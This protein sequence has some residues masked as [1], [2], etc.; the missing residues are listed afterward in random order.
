MQVSRW[1]SRKAAEL[2]RKP[3]LLHDRTWALGL[4]LACLALYWPTLSPSVVLSDGGE[5]QM[6]SYVLGVAHRTG[7]PLY[8]LLGWVVTHLPL[9]GDVAYRLNLFSMFSASAAMAVVYLLLRELDVR[10]GVAALSTLL[11]AS[12]P[13]LWMHAAAA[14]VYA[15]AVFFVALGSWLLLR[16]GRGK[17]PLWLV[18]L[19]FGLGLTHH[20]TF[21]LL[22]PAVL[23]YILLVEPRLPLRPRRWLPALV[24]LLLPLLL[25]AWIPLRAAHF[26]AQPGLQGEILGVPKVVASGYISTWYMAVGPVDFFL[27]A[28]Y[29]GDVVRSVGLDPA[30]VSRYLAMAQ[31]Q[32]P[33]ILVLPLALLG[34][35]AMLRHRARPAAYFLL[36]YLVTT[37]AAIRF[38][39]EVGGS[40]NQLLTGYVL[41]VLWFA[42]GVNLLLD[43]L[44]KRWQPTGWK[45][46]LPLV[47]LV[48]IPLFNFVQHYPDALTRR[49]METKSQTEA[50][51]A[52]PLP[53][54]AVIAGGD[55]IT[56][57]RYVQR[58]CGVRPDLWAIH[59][60][61]PGI[62]DV[63]LPRAL[64]AGIPLYALR[65][66]EAGLRLLPLMPDDDTAIE[67]SM[68][69]RLGQI[70]RWRG[71]S[72]PDA[73]VAPGTAL[74]ITL[75]W[76][77]EA[78]IDQ[79]WKTFIH[80]L[81]EGGEKVAQVDRVPLEQFHPP[82]RWQPGRLVV[83]QYEL[84]LPSDLGPGRY[85]LIFGWYNESE[86]LAWEGGQDY[87]ALGYIE[88]AP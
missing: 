56:L 20:I 61:E 69:K 87:Q 3:W 8:V 7:Y 74:P 52:L 47:L 1:I 43:W 17:T 59:A 19:V 86:R 83:D 71:Y 62:R 77:V 85:Q 23:V 75:Y 22:G 57:V 66:T 30:I 11:L 28:D 68:D 65:G 15:L 82:T 21:R 73:A 80:L 67:N 5:F 33:L 4:F 25:Y 78:P 84:L 26:Q 64:E 16:W 60:N 39:G 76:Q 51:L 50:I 34:L 13:G 49:Q 42:V 32:Y 2:P 63:L 6:V 18:T 58:I 46:L 37:W 72:L 27:V 36:V 81:D 9:G 70:V 48:C 10:K 53:E 41:T 45:R 88:V 79:D 14:E 40:S 55:E 12:A 29:S 44:H 31:E 54:G 35:A 24:T 38:L